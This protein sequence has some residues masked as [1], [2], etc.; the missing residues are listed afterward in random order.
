MKFQKKVISHLNKCYSIAS[1]RSQD[2]LCFLVAAEKNDPCFLFDTTGRKLETVWNGP[3]G[4]MSMVQLPDRED[5]FLA[6]Q[7]F[8]S[9]ND[10]ADACIIMASRTKNHTWQTHTLCRLPF[11]HRFDILTVNHVRY[12]IACTL[13]SGHSSKDDWSSPGKV[14]AAVLPENLNIYNE[15]NP[16]LLTVLK[17]GLFKNHG[18]CRITEDGR[19]SSLIA[20]Q[21][22]VFQFLPPSA[23]D[24]DWKILQLLAEPAS[25]AVLIDMDQ[26]GKKE[27]VT[28]S[29]FH[30]DT[31]T[32]YHQ[33]DN[34]W[35]PVYTY[36]AK[37]EFSHA[38]WAGSIGSVNA[39]IIGHRK[40]S[41]D[42]LLFTYDT[43]SSTYQ[44]QKIDE[45]CG[46]ANVLVLQDERRQF[47]VAANREID[48]VALYEI[49]SAEKRSKET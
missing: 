37:A 2:K 24:Q 41:R 28:L 8:Y 21:N 16:L 4:V 19:E 22:G 32:F 42:L 7:R 1:L 45:D 13:K 35:E 3:G 44:Y 26:D 27:L 6:T 29:P 23:P 34:H 12:L 48:E 20:S 49:E 40:G 38:I 11:V 17:D 47:L 14:Y 30:G 33:E 39:V 25:D 5:A 15:P 31:I 9:P 46:A 18:Y 10:S 43:A 36:P